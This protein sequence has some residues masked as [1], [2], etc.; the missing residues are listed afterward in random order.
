M[1]DSKDAINYSISIT[2]TLYNLFDRAIQ[3]EF[4]DVSE[5]NV[6]ITPSKVADYQCNS[7]MQIASVI[8][9]LTLNTSTVLL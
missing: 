5:A 2:D 6:I 4:P 9:H 7:S 1:C 8:H 3:A